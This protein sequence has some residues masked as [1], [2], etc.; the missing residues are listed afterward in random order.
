M[1]AVTS[2]R[3]CPI[4]KYEKVVIRK[5]K[6]LIWFHVVKYLNHLLSCKHRSAFVIGADTVNSVFG[7]VTYDHVRVQSWILN[8]DNCCEL[9]M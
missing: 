2:C 5:H 3:K 7:V 8:V 6:L 1:S 9:I 4:V